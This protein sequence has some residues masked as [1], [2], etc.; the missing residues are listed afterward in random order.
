MKTALVS[1]YNIYLYIKLL[2][3]CC[4]V[5]KV[6]SDTD[7]A[8]LIWYNPVH[9]KAHF[10]VFAS[11]VNFTIDTKYFKNH[12]RHLSTHKKIAINLERPNFVPDSPPPKKR[13][14]ILY[15][16]N[17]T[18]W[19]QN[20]RRTRNHFCSCIFWGPLGYS[21][22]IACRAQSSMFQHWGNGNAALT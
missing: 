5:T 8:Q 6:M 3:T 15:R 1:F 11:H 20:Y 7:I 12:N 14:I 9:L 4:A 21:C 10:C 19:K 17:E 13:W 22:W 16:I 18:S 2:L